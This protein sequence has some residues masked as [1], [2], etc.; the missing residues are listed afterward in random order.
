[1]NFRQ[2]FTGPGI[3]GFFDL[4]WAPIYLYI[5]FVIHPY[6]GFLALI[7]MA[8]SVCFTIFTER[9]VGSMPETLIKG[10]SINKFVYQHLRLG[11]W[12]LFIIYPQI[13]EENGLIQV[14]RVL[15]E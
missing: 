8:F 14:H 1:M 2:W 4:P 6:L 7:L 10:G 11:K 9:S 5:M 12:F 15:F 13:S 3:F